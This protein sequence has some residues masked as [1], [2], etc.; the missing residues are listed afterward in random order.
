MPLGGDGR[1]RLVLGNGPQGPLPVDTL[2]VG[3][4]L[5]YRKAQDFLHHFS[6]HRHNADF[7]RVSLPWVFYREVHGMLP[8]VASSAA[9]AG[10]T[11]PTGSRSRTRRFWNRTG[12]FWNSRTKR[13]W[14]GPGYCPGAPMPKGSWRTIREHARVRRPPS[15]TSASR[16][17]G[18]AEICI[19]LERPPSRSRL[20]GRFSHKY[21]FGQ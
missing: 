16:T 20:Q 2:Y 12:K 10:P 1:W 19:V 9:I 15:V 6:F 5:C 8:D 17:S 13:F 11:G 3:H 21:C 18:S 4:S 7:S 14:W